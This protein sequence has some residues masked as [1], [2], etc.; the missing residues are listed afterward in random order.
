MVLRKVTKISTHLQV[1]LKTDHCV[2]KIIHLW[3]LQF[4]R[5]L[6]T[7]MTDFNYRLRMKYNVWN[8]SANISWKNKPLQLL[9]L[10][11]LPNSKNI[12]LTFE[13]QNIFFPNKMNLKFC[14]FCILHYLLK[15]KTHCYKANYKE[16]AP[17]PKS[18]II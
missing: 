8:S 18:E 6:L 11:C 9:Y 10:F 2:S 13:F 17:C 7:H 3:G 16:T 15:I 14:I 12:I 5:G 1:S 4:N